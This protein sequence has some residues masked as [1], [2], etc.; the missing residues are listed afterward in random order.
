MDKAC[1]AGQVRELPKGYDD[2]K[3][4]YSLTVEEIKAAAEFRGG[5]FLGPEKSIGEKGAIF[6]WECENGHR[7]SSSLEYVLLGGGWCPECGYE[8]EIQKYD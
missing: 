7:F 6:D 5:R 1:A 8:F 4:I 2:S 3:S